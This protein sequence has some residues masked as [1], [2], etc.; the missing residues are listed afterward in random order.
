M[1][2]TDY[3]DNIPT[4][5]LR[6]CNL[7]QIGLHDASNLFRYYNNK[8][9]YQ[10]LDWNG[11]SSEEEAKKIINHWN[12]GFKDG[13]IIRFGIVD[14]QQNELIGTIFLNGFEGRRCEI[15]YELSEEYWNKGIMSDAIKA[16][17]D[18]ALS[19]LIEHVFKQQFALKILHQNHY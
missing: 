9:V 17:I 8:N 5:M 18:L 2:F 10:Y 12:H 4:F 3:F 16:M 11:P 13:W 15:G 19:H 14:P 6:T 1:N 7:R